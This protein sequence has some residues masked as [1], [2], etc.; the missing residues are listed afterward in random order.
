[1]AVSV[2]LDVG[3]GKE[4]ASGDGADDGR[5][6]EAAVELPVAVSASL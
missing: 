5:G 6:A 4:V 3:E 2:M 1:M